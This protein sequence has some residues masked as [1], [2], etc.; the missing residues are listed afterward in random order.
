MST[1][2][3]IDI[4]FAGGMKVDARLGDTVI[5]T[6]Q[7]V[8]DGGGASAPTPFA[9]FLASLATC[10]GLYAKRFCES[11][12][13]STQGLGL[14][15]VCTYADKGFHVDD[16]IFEI[17]LPTGFPEKY[18]DALLR[19]VDLCTV[20]KHISNPPQFSVRIV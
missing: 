5:R 1:K 14:R 20:K 11:R 9:L 17:T 13:I 16:I 10:A 4:E 7:S 18:H 6:D 15:A 19:A 8:K 2:N 12:E 3:I